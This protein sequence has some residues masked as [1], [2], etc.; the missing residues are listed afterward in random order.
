[1]SQD[2]VQ[3]ALQQ[4]I[5]RYGP[6]GYQ[7]VE[8]TSMPAKLLRPKSQSPLVAAATLLLCLASAILIYIAWFASERDRHV[9]LKA[10]PGVVLDA[11]GDEPLPPRE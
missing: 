7:A 5:D 6:S 2:E 10:S 9:E 3:E 11:T 1:M 4:E 8:Q